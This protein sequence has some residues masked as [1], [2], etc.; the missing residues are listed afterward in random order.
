MSR[1]MLEPE[2]RRAMLARIAARGHGGGPKSGRSQ[3]TAHPS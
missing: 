2:I 1:P 3:G